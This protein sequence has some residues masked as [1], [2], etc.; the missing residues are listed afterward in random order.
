MQAGCAKVFATYLSFRDGPLRLASLK[1][2]QSLHSF[3]PRLTAQTPRRLSLL[4]T[5]CN[6]KKHQTIKNDLNLSS[7]KVGRWF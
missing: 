5:L 1:C 4:N 7:P 2:I 6:T 3:S